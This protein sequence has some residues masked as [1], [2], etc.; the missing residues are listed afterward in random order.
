MPKEEADELEKAGKIA[1]PYQETSERRQYIEKIVVDIFK[2]L[3]KE[4]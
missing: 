2:K 3:R 1:N 4:Q